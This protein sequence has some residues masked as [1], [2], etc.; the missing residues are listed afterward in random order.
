[1]LEI[2]YQKGNT[3]LKKREILTLEEKITFQQRVSQRLAEEEAPI[4]QLEVAPR[5]KLD[6]SGR[7][8]LLWGTFG[9]STGYYSW[10]VPVLF[11]MEGK[12]GVATGLLTSVGS[13]YLPYEATKTIP[14]TES[15]ATMSIWGGT[16]GI[17]HGMALTAL[18]AGEDGTFRGYVGMSMTFSIGEAVLGF[19]MANFHNLEAGQ[20]MQINF[21]SDLGLYWGIAAGQLLRLYGNS[22]ARP[23]ASMGLLGTGVG[24][25]TG[26]KLAAEHHYSKGDVHIQYILQTLGA[27][28][29]LAT[30]VLFESENPDIYIGGLL[31]GSFA[32][33]RMGHNMIKDKDFTVGQGMLME[34]GTSAGYSFGLALAYL[35]T[36]ED[37]GSEKPYIALSTLGAIGGFWVTYNAFK[38]E[39]RHEHEQNQA[40]D[41]KLY[42]ESLVINALGD[43]LGWE[44]GVKMPFVRASVRF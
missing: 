24:M 13:F 18:L 10:A 8:K 38:V 4:E 26:S 37:G 39:A 30:I 11:N 27:M 14:V 15:A 44:S 31:T 6:H 34:L 23:M 3:L 42:P 36:P 2:L 20:T 35:V 16:R 21:I 28:V 19:K 5:L 12:L 22:M 40:W 25:W 41:F 1:M 29:P 33:L 43:R 7:A 17:L 32:A 9:L